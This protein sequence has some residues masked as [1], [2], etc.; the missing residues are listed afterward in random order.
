[1]TD[2]N[3]DFLHLGIKTIDLQHQKFFQLLVELRLYNQSKEDNL[4]IYNIIEEF[5]E[6]TIYHF[7]AEEK[8]MS[9]INFPD[10]DE[11][12]QQ[13]EMFIKKIDNFKTAYEYQSRM[14]SEQILFFLQKWFLVHIQEYDAK[15]VNY[16]NNSKQ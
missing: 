16:I 8:I 3:I 7:N 4:A 6:Y 5:T 10:I 13:H 15:Y 9:K 12:L 11:H 14:L 2:L 1:M